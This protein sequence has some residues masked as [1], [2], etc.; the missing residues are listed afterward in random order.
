MQQMPQPQ[1]P[2]LWGA[3]MYMPQAG[4]VQPLLPAPI[5]A[6]LPPAFRVP[7]RGP[8]LIAQARRSGAKKRKGGKPDGPQI[9]N[10]VANPRAEPAQILHHGAPVGL[11][12]PPPAPGN[13]LPQF[14]FGLADPGGAGIVPQQPLYGANAYAV[15]Q[16]QQRLQ[17]VGDVNERLRPNEMA[18]LIN[19]YNGVLH[20]NE[21]RAGVAGDDPMEGQL[22]R[23]FLEAEQRV[24]R[25]RMA[26]MQDQQRQLMNV[27][28]MGMYRADERGVGIRGGMPIVPYNFGGPQH[29]ARK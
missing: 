8:A 15:Q 28:P 6:V 13:V 29:Q 12:N 3:G 16:H 7:A 9:A 10:H 25:H 22:E 17:E 26:L 20:P 5:P 1:A 18:R 21:W 14:R 27:E 2:G 24:T 11:E 4:V 19:P 23:R